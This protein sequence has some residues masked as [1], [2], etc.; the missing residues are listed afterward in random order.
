MNGRKPER[1][2]AYLHPVLW[3]S[4][5]KNNLVKGTYLGSTLQIP[6]LYR[7]KKLG[8]TKFN[9]LCTQSQIK[10]HLDSLGPTGIS[11]T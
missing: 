2:Y 9:H 3:P 6:L 8:N 1:N 11:N 5:K 4:T 7:F 10:A